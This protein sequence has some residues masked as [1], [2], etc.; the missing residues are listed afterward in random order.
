M[1][2][3]L[4]PVG[5]PGRAKRATSMQRSLAEPAR[6]GFWLRAAE[7]HDGS[8]D[9]AQKGP[10]GDCPADAVEHRNAREGENPEPDDGAEIG[11]DERGDDTLVRVPRAAL[12]LEE[13]TVI[14]ADRDDQKKPEQVEDREP[15][16]QE[17]GERR[18]AGHG[19]GEWC[20]DP[21]D[22]RR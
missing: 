21:R 10:D 3:R 6:Q 16:L 7:A 5:S 15:S 18:R 9:K 19:R 20:H 12:P 8:E 22:P 11:E 14:G 1:T 17:Q 4:R 2:T 13:E